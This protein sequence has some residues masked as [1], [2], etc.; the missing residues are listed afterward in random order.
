MKNREEEI[1]SI[2]EE[3][4][5]LADRLE[6]LNKPEQREP[7]QGDVWRYTSGSPDEIIITSKGEGAPSYVYIRGNKIGLLCGELGHFN[8]WRDEWEYL[9]KFGDYSPPSNNR[10]AN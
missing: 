10:Q 7:K 5:K 1:N 4:R 3:Q 6:A 9:G 8:V 2:K